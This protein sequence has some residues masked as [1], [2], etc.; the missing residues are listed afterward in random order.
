MTG[1]PCSMLSKVRGHIQD[2]ATRLTR[3]VISGSDFVYQL[4][5]AFDSRG[6]AELSVY[7]LRDRHSGRVVLRGTS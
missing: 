2:Q 6:R 4:H 7:N 1:D 3:H 5:Q